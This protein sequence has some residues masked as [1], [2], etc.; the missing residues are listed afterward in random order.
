MKSSLIISLASCALSLTA[1]AEFQTWTSKDGKAA[2]LELVSVSDSGGE[3][4]G[5][6]KMKTGKTVSIKASALSEADAARLAEWKPAETPAGEVAEPAAGPPSVFDDLL[7]GNLVQLDGK[8][9]GR[10]KEL[11][12][13]EKY[14]IF[15]Y[16]ASW[17]APC[18]KFTPSLVEFYNK[19][20]NASFEIYF[21]SSDNDEGDMEGYM[22][23]KSMPWPALKLGKS[24][25]FKKE[26]KHGVAGI[27]F[28]AVTKP[29]GTVVEKGNAYPMLSKLQALVK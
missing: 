10:A 14:Y 28:I 2:E 6:F 24:D 22:K 21:I 12:K 1:M 18:Q 16:S 4:T 11:A 19:S 20:K 8:K 15:Y 7:D 29:D 17:C 23:D 25:K 13:P 5:E 3:K 9:V 27:P 26:I